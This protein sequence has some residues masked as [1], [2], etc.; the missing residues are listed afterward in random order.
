MSD[1]TIIWRSEPRHGDIDAVRDV[2]VSSG[3]FNEEEIGVAMELVEER[4]R[5]GAASGYHFIFAEH[6]GRMVGY[7]CYGPI[8][9]TK[10]SFDLYWI[11][12]HESGRGGGLGHDIMARAEAAIAAAGGTRVYVETSSRPQY[13]PTRAFYRRHGYRREALLEDF[14]GPGDGKEIYVKVV[15]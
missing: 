4:L 8:A 3:F 7:A 9:G 12:V 13:E 1:K 10:S 14:Y 2:V 6:K 5:R 11:A 15:S